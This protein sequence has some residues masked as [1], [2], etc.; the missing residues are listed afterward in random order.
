MDLSCHVSR[1]QF[2]IILLS[3]L[4]D[5]CGHAIRDR[6]PCPRLFMPSTSGI[7]GVCT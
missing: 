5:V 3:E 6:V 4:D 2:S 1:F 7:N